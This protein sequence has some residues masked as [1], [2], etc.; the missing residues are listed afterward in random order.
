MAHDTLLVQLPPWDPRTVPLGIAYLA[1]FLKS[2]GVSATVYD[3]N[4]EM[5]NSLNDERKKGWGNEDFHWWQSKK[6][7]ER[8]ALMFEQLYRRLLQ[9]KFYLTHYI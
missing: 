5:Y 7:E 1:S 3:L 4:I 2:K 9:H 8:Y 6:L